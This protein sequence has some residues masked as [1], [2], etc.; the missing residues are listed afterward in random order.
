MSR[1]GSALRLTRR[2]LAASAVALSLSSYCAYTTAGLDF[3]R[4]APGGGFEV[5]YY[6]LRWD[7]GATWVGRAVQPVGRPDHAPDWGDPGGTWLDRPSR[8]ARRTA[9]NRWGFWRV[10]GPSDDPYVPLRYPGATSSRWVAVP[11]W[12]VVAAALG[13]GLARAGRSLGR[14][15]R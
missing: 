15:V 13:P 2:L 4:E 1:A 8:P 5:A 10:D 6:R 3:E 9:W 7:D 14:P 12:L 11:S